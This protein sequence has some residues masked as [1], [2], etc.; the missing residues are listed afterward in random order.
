MTT[1]RWINTKV[2]LEWNGQQYV[3]TQ[4][5]GYWYDGPMALAEESPAEG[6]PPGGNG[7]PPPTVPEW[8]QS[9]EDEGLKT[10]VAGFES[11]DKLFEAIGYEPSKAPEPK[12]W[13]DGLPDE[14]KET[15]ERFASAEDAIRSIQTLRKRDSQIRVP[16]KDATDEERAAY[17]K[18][19][20]VPEKPDGYEFP[21]L[22]KD[23]LTDEAKASRQEWSQLFH[24]L[25]VPKDMARALFDAVAADAEKQ[26]QALIEA[27]KAFAKEQEDKLRAEWKT[28][29]DKNHTL[30][31]RAFDEVASRAGLNLEDLK[32]IETKDGRFLMDDSNMLR[33]FAVI[34]RE[35][36]E[37][38]LGP[39]LTEGE[40]E[41]ID[42]QLRDLRKQIVEAQ[43]EG[44]NKRANQ[45]YQREQ[46]LI[47]KKEG[48]KPVVGAAGRTA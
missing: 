32:R 42:E 47:A 31:N 33:L 36:A 2:V 18:A 30:A 25:Q 3:K 11:Q 27:D 26:Q 6:D 38:T 1:K 20:G 37:G 9:I 14:L 29:F 13:R 16:G 34:G 19:V 7:N 21:P 8:A 4:G 35:M 23:Q 12:D 22:S 39:T 48:S 46:R 44:D 40:I 17:L 5:E 43:S 41:T 24:K 45:L 28:D 10:A 15:A